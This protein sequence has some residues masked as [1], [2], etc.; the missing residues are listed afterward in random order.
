MA[1]SYQ[2]TAVYVLN[3]TG[4]SSVVG[5]TP[6]DLWFDKKA[7]QNEKID[8]F[9]D[10]IFPESDLNDMPIVDSSYLLVQ[11]NAKCGTVQRSAVVKLSSISKNDIIRYCG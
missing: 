1:R 3:R 9:F 5:K 6:Y 2:Y 10:I 11:P 8:F 7:T 4:T